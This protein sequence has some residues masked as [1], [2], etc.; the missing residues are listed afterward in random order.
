MAPGPSC[1]QLIGLSTADQH[2]RPTRFSQRGLWDNR[3]PFSAPTFDGRR[4]TDGPRA[5]PCKNR[6]GGDSSLPSHRLEQTHPKEIQYETAHHD[7][8]KADAGAARPGTSGAEFCLQA[9]HP[10][11]TR[12]CSTAAEN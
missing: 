11:P 7:L 4:E 5:P 2:P 10:P 1:A 8:P 12:R 9:R 3:F 6:V